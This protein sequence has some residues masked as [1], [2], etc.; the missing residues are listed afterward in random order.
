MGGDHNSKFISTSKKKFAILNQ[1]LLTKFVYFFVCHVKQSRE[2]NI[3]KYFQS[4]KL[5]FG[6]T[7]FSGLHKCMFASQFLSRKKFVC[8]F[9]LKEKEKKKSNRFSNFVLF[10]ILNLN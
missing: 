10:L 6:I 4:S 7:E 2:S 1:R 8:K 3:Q 9:K 5:H